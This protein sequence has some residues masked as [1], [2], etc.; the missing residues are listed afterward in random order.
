MGG[1][2]PLLVIFKVVMHQAA[3]YENDIIPHNQ[4]IG[5]SENGQTMNEIG[6][7]QLNLFYEY[8]KD[9]TVS[10]HR[11]LVLDG[12]GSHVN[13][14]FN[15]FCLDR[16]IIVVYI[17]AHLLYLLQPLNIGCF[18]ALKQAYGRSVK[19]L[20]SRGVNHINKHKFLP[21][22]RQARQIALHQNNIQA[23]FVATGLIPYSPDRVL[24][25]LYA[26][27]QTPLPQRCPQSNASQAAEIP[28]NITELQQQTALLRR[29][30]KQRTHTLPSPTE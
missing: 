29:Y 10:T 6:L 21:L 16:K 18:L 20:I 8:I 13:L 26:E 7:T 22:Y 15:Q 14:K 9:R 12:Y 11:L 2:I 28:H 27:Y 23:G 5:V 24:L 4:L 25:Q 1:I 3:W 17:L 19:Q 30:L